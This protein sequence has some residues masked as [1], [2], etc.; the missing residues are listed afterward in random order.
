VFVVLQVAELRI[1]QSCM[2]L[3][4]GLCRVVSEKLIDVSEVF[5]ALMMMAL[6]TSEAFVSFY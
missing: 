2:W 6:S 5:V 3:S 1:V 4:S